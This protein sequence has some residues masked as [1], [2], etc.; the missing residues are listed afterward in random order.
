LNRIL[1]GKTSLPHF[2]G[3]THEPIT[4]LTAD[5]LVVVG[6]ILGRSYKKATVVKHRLFDHWG[7]SV[8][9]HTE[10]A[11]YSE[12]FAGSGETAVVILVK[13]VLQAPKNSLLLFDEPETSLHPGAQSKILEFLLDQ[14][15][16]NQHQIV[17]C[18][19]APAMVEEL[20]RSAVKVFTPAAGGRFQVRKDVLPSE[21][22]FF[23]GQPIQNKK[24][25]VVEDRLA[26]KMVDAVLDLSGDATKSLFEVCYFPGGESQMKKDA[27][28]YS[29]SRSSK[30]FLL[31]DG[32]R[33]PSLPIFNPDELTLEIN[34]DPEK[35]IEVL[36]G[37]I[38]EATGSNI[39]FA[40]D[41]HIGKGSKPQ[42]RDLRKEY[43][44]YYRKNCFFLP[45][46]SPEKEIWDN[47]CI[48]KFLSIIFSQQE[49]A[50]IK[51][52]LAGEVDFKKKFV[53]LTNALCGKSS[54][55]EIS[56]VHTILVKA[57]ITKN[58]PF[59]NETAQVLESIKNVA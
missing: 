18:T 12:A 27:T 5:E 46:E 16:K 52:D 6:K 11:S 24:I 48:D 50:K 15:I 29:R 45:M 20:P 28:M 51:A 43:L 40:S 8:I 1:K 26:K 42:Q 19:H 3:K 4:D 21:A 14:C 23:L 57:W 34:D 31:F 59:V 38:K 13:E 35:A 58:P 54:G 7:H 33:K 49:V 53:I 37:H 10:H 55:D 9:L 36:N 41:G 39:E 30:T 2:Q 22:F 17:Y 44:K 25:I 47:E 32:D 56:M